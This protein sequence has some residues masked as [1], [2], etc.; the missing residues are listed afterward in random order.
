MP[1]FVL[2]LGAQVRCIHNGHATP[3]VT[4]PRVRVSTQPVAVHSA[5]CVIAGCILPP[6]P[7]ANGPCISGSWLAPSLRVKAMGMPLLVAPS[8]SVCAPT[9]TPM[10][11]LM[12]QGRV[13]AM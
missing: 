1:S 8:P 12:V 2:H 4:V 5:P 6:P 11:V 10:V 3:S 9:G 13:T 7:A